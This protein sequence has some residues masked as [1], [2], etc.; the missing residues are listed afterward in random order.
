MYSLTRAQLDT[1]SALIE[2]RGF[3]IVSMQ[4]HPHSGTATCYGQGRVALLLVNQ[5]GRVSYEQ[6]G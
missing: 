3:E 1:I 6:R 5:N 4:V 2:T